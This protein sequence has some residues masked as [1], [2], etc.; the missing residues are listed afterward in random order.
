M[1]EYNGY[2]NYETWSAHLVLSNEETTARRLTVRARVQA[3]HPS[4]TSEYW[5]DAQAAVFSFADGLR[6]EI[7]GWT[8]DANVALEMAAP[9]ILGGQREAFKFLLPQLLSAAVQEINYE[10]LAAAFMPEEISAAYDADM[11]AGQ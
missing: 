8:A 11:E 2:T 4:K 9:A 1:S 6:E 5:T 3:A 10:E 7:S